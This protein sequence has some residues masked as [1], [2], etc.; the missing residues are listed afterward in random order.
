MN[1]LLNEILVENLSVSTPPHRFASARGGPATSALS[2]PGDRTCSCIPTFT[3]SFPRAVSRPTIVVGPPLAILF[4]LPVK[5]LSRV[6][7]GKC[8][9]G[10]KRLHHHNKL[11]C[12]GPAAALADRQQFAKLVRR[13]HRHDWVV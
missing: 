12:A 11:C 9:A 2:T 5:A 3:V 6:F 13:L 4:F 1:L 8:L 7:R 10:L